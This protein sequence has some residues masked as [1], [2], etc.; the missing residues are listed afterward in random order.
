MSK[1]Q[2][3]KRFFSNARSPDDWEKD[4][5]RMVAYVE[6]EGGVTVNLDYPHLKLLHQAKMFQEFKTDE[7]KMIG[8][9][10]G[11]VK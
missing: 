6:R 8:K 1:E 5:A 4:Y 9:M 10:L 7:F 3:L 2:K 11:A